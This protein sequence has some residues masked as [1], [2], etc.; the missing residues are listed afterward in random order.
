MAYAISHTFRI[1]F[2][3]KFEN[4]GMYHDNGNIT[5]NIYEQQKNSTQFSLWIITT[6]DNNITQ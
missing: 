4:N 3:Y 2:F 1:F 6:L 5:R